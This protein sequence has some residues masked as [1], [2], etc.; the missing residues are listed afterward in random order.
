MSC[1]ALLRARPLCGFIVAMIALGAL[2]SAFSQDYILSAPNVT[3]DPGGSATLALSLDNSGGLLVTG[4]S[5]SICFDPNVVI[6]LTAVEGA[7]TLALNGGSGPDFFVPSI[8]PGSVTVGMVTDLLGTN[9]YLSA[10]GHEFL[11]ITFGTT[12][13]P[14]ESTPLQFCTASSPSISSLVIHDPNQTNSV[15]ALIDGSI[16]IGPFQGA[17]LAIDAS[18]PARPGESVIAEV[19]L[20]ASEDVSAID[21]GISYDGSDLSL[22]G[23]T[24]VGDLAAVNGG[25]GPSVFLVDFAPGGAASGV[26]V[27]VVVDTVAPIGLLPAG[28]DLPVFA[29]EFAVAPAAGPVCA[30]R[31]LTFNS[32]LGSPPVE[33]LVTALSGALVTST[34]DGVLAIGAPTTVPPSGGITLSLDTVFPTA[35]Q[36]ATVSIGLD[37][38]QAISAVSFG[39]AFNSTDVSLIGVAPGV[40]LAA[41]RCGLGPELFLVDVSGGASGGLTIDTVLQTTPPFSNRLLLPD[42]A[43]EFVVLQ[44]ATVPIPSIGGT[45]LTFTSTL[46]SPA[47][48]LSVVTPLGTITPTT[49]N[50]AIDL[51]VPFIRGNCNVDNNID[52]ADAIFILGVLFPGQGGASVITCRDACDLNDDGAINIGDPINLLTVLFSAGTPPTIPEPTTCGL[53]PTGS[54][55][56]SCEEFVACP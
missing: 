28:F 9:G 55:G 38:D 39:I 54:D 2:P 18:F 44:F 52:I 40:T 15:P 20:D 22:A 23:V 47:V 33:N 49:V 5:T 31:A 30:T 37:S 48:P 11:S 12:G 53:D 32:G 1:P 42:G 25:S 51:A 41:A 36:P 45:A 6:A 35:G 56:L 29:L 26:T 21:F 10:A 3:I 7:A 8:L 24:A 13:A 50:G 34:I 46:G 14:L 43:A 27:E 19:L 16:A 17:V 4:I